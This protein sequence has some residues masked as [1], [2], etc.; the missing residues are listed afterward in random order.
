MVKQLFHLGHC[1]L[2]SVSMILPKWF[3]SHMRQICT[4]RRAKCQIHASSDSTVYWVYF[5][6][7]NYNYRHAMRDLSLHHKAHV[8]A[9]SWRGLTITVTRVSPSR[10]T[11]HYITI[12]WDGELCSASVKCILRKISRFCEVSVDVL[13]VA[14]PWALQ[15]N[16]EFNVSGIHWIFCVDICRPAVCGFG[17]GRINTGYCR[18]INAASW[19]FRTT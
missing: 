5:S 12:Y 2:R 13:K 1:V 14:S 17:D 15:Q 3:N 10:M 18:D 11:N 9:S 6:R 7:E 19:K 4:W 16:V 8:N